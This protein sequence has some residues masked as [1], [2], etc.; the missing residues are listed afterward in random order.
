MRTSRVG[1]LETFAPEER[2]AAL[3]MHPL[4][5]QMEARHECTQEHH[6]HA[7]W[8]DGRG[9]D[10]RGCGLRRSRDDDGGCRSSSSSVGGCPAITANARF[11]DVRHRR[12]CVVCNACPSSSCCILNLPFLFFSFTIFLVAFCGALSFTE[13]R[14]CAR[15]RARCV[16]VIGGI[17]TACKEDATS[18]RRKTTKC[19]K[20]KTQ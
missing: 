5:H 10:A 1:R 12:H 8:V 18:Y 14:T 13:R 11:R 9:F 16:C 20:A 6:H 4:R 2:A 3:C 15:V 17:A 19:L 7:H